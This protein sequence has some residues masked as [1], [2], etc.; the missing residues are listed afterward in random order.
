MEESGDVVD[1]SISLFKDENSSDPGSVHE[2]TIAFVGNPSVG[3]SAFFSRVTGVGVIVSNY[4]GTTVELTHGTMRFDSRTVDLVDLPGIYSLGAATEDEKVSKRYLLTEHPDVIV[5][6]LDATRLERNLYLTLQLLELNIPVV[7]AL[8]QMD[9]AEGMGMEIDVQKLSSMLGVPVIPTIA[10]KGLGLYDVISSALEAGVKE[11]CRIKVYYDDHIRDALEKLDREFPHINQC[12]KM[13]ALQND[14]DFV[15]LCCSA[16]DADELLSA[17]SGS[18]AEDIE[19][20]HEMSVPDT[21]AH[22]VFGEAGYIVDS[23]VSRTE[24]KKT[25]KDRIDEVLT[26]QDAGIITLVFAL[27]LTFAMVFYIGGFLEEGIVNLFETYVVQPADSMTAGMNPVVQNI[28]IYALLGIEA[29]FAIAIP[30]IGVFYIIL[31]ILEDSGY[32]TRAA[33]LLDTLTHR[34]GLHGRAVIPLILGYGCNVPAIM[35]TRALNTLRERRIASVL[36][37]LTPCS[38]RTVI[39]L[40]LVGTFVGYWAAVS[41]YVLQLFIIYS[42]GWVLG[43]GLPGER[44]GFIMEMSPLRQPDV[45]ATLQKTWIRIREFV[46]IAF[47]LLIVGSALLGAVEAMGLLDVF[48][49]A[50]EPL[51]VGLLGLPAFAATALIFGILRKEMALEILAVLAGTANFALVMTPLQ[52]YVF[53][54]VTTIYIPCVATIVILKHELGWKDTVG[55]IAFTVS[56]ALVIGA[57][58]NFA[59]PLLV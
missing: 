46:Y 18:I 34:L 26:S 59:A 49:T 20:V 48:E 8:N 51:S 54:V 58:I 2:K 24:R 45:M 39:I 40:G 38:A 1:I 41:I 16:E 25:V 10:T 23:V 44:T 57:L 11:E 50:V 43:K 5:N 47:P 37:S 32:L 28:L 29:G 13:R 14:S 42:T 3:K 9:A 36:I 27:L 7:V 35:S 55:I 21:I 4:P 56:L 53:A 33:F 15:N 6:V 22:D 30:Y 17:A 19:N 31:S 12:V 52:M